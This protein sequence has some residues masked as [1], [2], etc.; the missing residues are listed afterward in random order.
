V[1]DRLGDF[2]IVGG[3]G[4]GGSSIV[5]SARGYGR[6]L[7]LK[8][9]QSDGPITDADRA[10]FVSEA[11]RMQRISHPSL[12][13][14]LGAGFLPDGRPFIAMPR[15]RGA[16]VAE[17]AT[18]PVPRDRAIGLFRGLARAVAAL[19]SAGLVH[20]D[21]KPENV[22]WLEEEDRLVLLDL[23]I[24][25][26]VDASP[27]TTTRA[28]FARGTPAYMAP[29]RLFGNA[30]SIRSDLY[31]LALVLVFM[32][33][34]RLPWDEGD[35]HA[36]ML[37][38]LSRLPPEL[39]PV[40]ERAL[41]ID[42]AKRPPTALQLL[43]WIESAIGASSSSWVVG[44]SQRPAPAASEESATSSPLREAHWPAPNQQAPA[45][46]SEPPVRV[47][48]DPNR[49]AHDPRGAATSPTAS[50][51]RTKLAVAAAGLTLAVA[52]AATVG[53]R[54]GAE[55]PGPSGAESSAGVTPAA[56]GAASSGRVA[57]H[58][59]TDAS[60]PSTT[61]SAPF[62]AA[63]AVA[64]SV[65]S[66]P[67]AAPSSQR[68]QASAVATGSATSAASVGKPLPASTAIPE[69]AGYVALMCDPSTGALANECQAAKSNTASWTAK[70]P[71]E[72][73]VETCRAARD[74]SKVG[75]AVRRE[76]KPP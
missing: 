10:R 2:E 37:P 47:A 14:L 33:L 17:R 11:E 4:E 3:L 63:P 36:R 61:P 18:M 34:G 28:G 8:V 13:T 49:A 51:S 43:D 26:E 54:L 56:E 35:P 41:S 72:V 25:R 59:P 55:V 39:V 70:L 22:F 16:T 38:D 29:E 12:V 65:T 27:S 9:F 67:T 66:T 71:R 62:S 20:R 40:F 5:Y 60:V 48:S 19:H 57:S 42:V 58:P 68:G 24:A 45:A 15:L 52:A 31:E 74:Q 7:A 44:P 69:C 73:A 32:L 46:A 23:G 50:R 53:L 64:S 21:I 30:A 6:D 1:P 76:W 75:L